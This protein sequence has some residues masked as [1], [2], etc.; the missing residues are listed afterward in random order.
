MKL[1][2]FEEYPDEAVLESLRKRLIRSCRMAGSAH[3]PCFI[4]RRAFR[5]QAL[6]PEKYVS[7]PVQVHL[8]LH[9]HRV[10]RDWHEAFYWARAHT[11]CDQPYCVNG[12]HIVIDPSTMAWEWLDNPNS[13]YEGAPQPRPWFDPPFWLE[14]LR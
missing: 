5:W 14:G 12:D 1:R 7:L 4:P 3:S 2:T 9:H 11:M 8:F 10:P 6:V 13:I